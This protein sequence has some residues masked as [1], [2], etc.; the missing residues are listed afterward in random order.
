MNQLNEIIGLLRVQIEAERKQS[1]PNC[2]EKIEKL[3]NQL[4]DC[5]DEIGDV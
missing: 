1:S 4:S 2:S 5:L 3:S